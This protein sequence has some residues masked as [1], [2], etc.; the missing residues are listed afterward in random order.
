MERLCKLF[1]QIHKV[2]HDTHLLP[3]LG[4]AAAFVAVVQFWEAKLNSEAQRKYTAWHLLNTAQN[5]GY[6]GGQVLAV[7]DLYDAGESLSGVSLEGAYLNNIKL[8]GIQFS[9]SILSKSKFQ[10]TDLSG[11]KLENSIAN[12]A[13]FSG[14]CL[15]G[16]D[17]RKSD[18]KNADLVRADLRGADLSDA[19]L[20]GAD[21]RFARL[22]GA[23]LRGANLAEADVQGASF[24]GVN[25]INAKLAYVKNW[26]SAL[27]FKES[28]V[29]DATWPNGFQS[30][31][32]R[33]G[34]AY[35]FKITEE[36]WKKSKNQKVSDNFH[37][38][39]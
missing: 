9:S 12:S 5:H 4:A 25:L 23:S 16:A 20:K 15:I 7:L 1:K 14:A 19:N 26:R 24:Y 13:I 21:L 6:S 29:R 18:L 27:T 35:S 38:E 30:E 2:V 36:E 39:L 22:D 17:M 11:S 3:Y 34:V 31:F 10:N 37:C 33:W 28:I 32:A 8:V